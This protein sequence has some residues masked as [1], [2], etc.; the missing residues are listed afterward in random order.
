MEND[1]NIDFWNEKKKKKKN[2]HGSYHLL[3]PAENC[4]EIMDL[5]LKNK[6][7]RISG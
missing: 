5:V 1:Y 2:D 6:N 7:Y 4:T 3:G